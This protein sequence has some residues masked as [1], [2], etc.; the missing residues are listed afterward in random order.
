MIRYVPRYLLYVETSSVSVSSV[1]GADDCSRPGRLGRW[2]FIVESLDDQQRLE[3]ADEEPGVW[4]S[5]LDLLATVRGLEALEQPSRV[6]LIAHS[7]YLNDR[8]NRLTGPFDQFMETSPET[9]WQDHYQNVDLWRRMEA[10]LG[11]HNVESCN[12]R[13]DSAHDQCRWQADKHH[14][15]VTARR[16][17]G[18][19]E[20][21]SR[22]RREPPRGVQRGADR[23]ARNL[24]VA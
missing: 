22:T 12:W 21:R 19:P 23:D 17:V 20:E 8:L 7:A 16:S 14:G 5:R 11:Y 10:A 4:G 18:I 13:L 15:L 24:A 9:P 6:T 3:V 2:R 1:V